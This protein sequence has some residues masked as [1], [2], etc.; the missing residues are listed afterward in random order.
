MWVQTKSK[1]KK[2]SGMVWVSILLVCMLLL[3]AGCAANRAPKNNATNNGT[4][5]QQQPE[6]KAP[7]NNEAQKTANQRITHKE[8]LE[9]ACKAAGVDRAA[10]KDFSV[11]LDQEGEKHRYEV[12]FLHEGHEYE[13][14]LNAADGAVLQESKEKKNADKAEEQATVT[15]EEALKA[16]LDTAKLTEQ[17]VEVT[18]VHLHEE[19][20]K[21]QYEVK[22]IAENVHHAYEI[23]GTS[24][25]VLKSE[26][27]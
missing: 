18:E 24:G 17:Q 25:D 15:H 3:S 8:A 10:V 14:E 27:K 20:G 5:V 16:A 2:V 21:P 4:A 13:Y 1:Q 6:E 26:K 11:D 19:D 22:F 9:L 12:E 23:D 7:I